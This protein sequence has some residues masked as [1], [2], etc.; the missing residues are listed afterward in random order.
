MIRRRLSHT[1]PVRWETF[2]DF[3]FRRQVV[4]DGV[5]G[6]GTAYPFASAFACEGRAAYIVREG[7]NYFAGIDHTWRAA[8]GGHLEAN[9]W[10]Q[11]TG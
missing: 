4:T 8:A 3:G 6:K 9:R 1:G 10:N 7:S 11:F 5:M 2:Q